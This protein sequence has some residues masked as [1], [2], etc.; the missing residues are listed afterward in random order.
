VTRRA[1]RL[2][3]WAVN[4]DFMIGSCTGAQNAVMFGGKNRCDDGPPQAVA[5]SE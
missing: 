4:A 3:E 5:A 1:R 2:H